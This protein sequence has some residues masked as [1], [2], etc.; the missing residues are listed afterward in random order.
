QR[1]QEQKKKNHTKKKKSRKATTKGTEEEMCAIA[2]RR[3]TLSCF[4]VW[5]SA[6]VQVLAQ[7][8]VIDETFRVSLD[9]PAYTRGP[10]VAID[11][12]HDNFHTAGGQYKPF[13]D[14]L[15]AD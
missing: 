2:C 1:R 15:I 7:Q 6:C 14:L 4:L 12:A 5:F 11:E 13:A 8:Q 3:M 9:K 10:T